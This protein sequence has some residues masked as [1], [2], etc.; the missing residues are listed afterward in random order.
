MGT[1]YELM[2]LVLDVCALCD[3]EHSYLVARYK[4]WRSIIDGVHDCTGI[5]HSSSRQLG[6]GFNPRNTNAAQTSGEPMRRWAW[7]WAF[8]LCAMA[9]MAVYCR[10]IYTGAPSWS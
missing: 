9:H 2:G 1:R 7:Y 4:R 8:T 3:C 10:D 5:F 6:S